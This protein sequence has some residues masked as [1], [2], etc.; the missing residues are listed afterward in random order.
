MLANSPLVMAE[1]M[2]VTL[3]IPDIPI[4][5]FL[6]SI[7][8]E[9]SAVMGITAV[10]ATTTAMEA[11]ILLPFIRFAPL[12]TLSVVLLQFIRCLCSFCVSNLKLT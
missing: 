9:A 1:S 3:M 6:K 10:A 8:V 7:F 5:F 2:L 12:C 4:T 11:A